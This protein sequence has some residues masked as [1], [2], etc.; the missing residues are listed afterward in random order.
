MWR[1]CKR[2][3]K[4]LKTS[5]SQVLQQHSPTV[6]ASL[7]W[8]FRVIKIKKSLD[9]KKTADKKRLI[10]PLHD[11]ILYNPRTTLHSFMHNFDIWTSNPEPLATLWSQDTMLPFTTLRFISRKKQRTLKNPREKNHFLL[12]KWSDTHWIWYYVLGLQKTWSR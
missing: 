3:K 9:D 8:R 1:M 12:S 4:L 11:F 10:C 6:P 2:T 5:P 7:E